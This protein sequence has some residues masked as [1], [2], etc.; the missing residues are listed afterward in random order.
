MVVS[1]GVA[2]ITVDEPHGLAVG[3]GVSILDVPVPLVIDT[4]TRVGTVGTVVTVDDHDLTLGFKDSVEIDGVD[5]AEFNGTFKIISVNNRKTIK[6]SMPN[7][8]PT[9]STGGNVLNAQR[10]D[11]SY[12]GLFAVASVPS[13]TS[14]TINSFPGATGSVS[15]GKVRCNIR[16][17]AAATYERALDA[18]TKQRTDKAWCIAVLNGVSA[19]KDRGTNTDFTAKIQRTDFY[20]Q[21]IQ[22]NLTIVVIRNTKDELSGRKS[23]DDMQELMRHIMKSIGF[24]EFPNNLTV[25]KSNPLVFTSHD[26]LLYDSSLYVHGFEFECSTDIYVEDTV[27]GDESVAFRDINTV[28]IPDVGGTTS[29]D[30]YINLDDEA[31][32]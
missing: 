11:K 4:I 13:A 3:N 26:T 8:G 32:P 12:N 18:Y 10:Y 31:L 28:Q 17:S 30:A 20:R 24:Y 7:T 5:D 14:F 23:R 29:A 25:G 2:T 19:S 22:E 9:S 1:G 27:G 15:S 16:I 21:Q 6:F